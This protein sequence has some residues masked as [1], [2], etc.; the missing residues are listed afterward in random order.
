MDANNECS[1]KRKAFKTNESLDEI[2]FLDA[3]L[4]LIYKKTHS[5]I[6]ASTKVITHTYTQTHIMHKQMNECLGLHSKDI[7]KLK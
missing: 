1:L 7:H 2:H 5:K 6:A 4:L 3:R